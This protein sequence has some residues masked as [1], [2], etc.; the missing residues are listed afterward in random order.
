MLGS[1]FFPARVRVAT[2]VVLGLALAFAP[3]VAADGPIP[4]HVGLVGWLIVREL[5]IGA[6]IGFL[7]RL[8]VGAAM[9]A[10]SLVG[11]QMGLA[12][13]RA[14]DP[15]TQIQ[16]SQVGLVL[17][18]I[19]VMGL[20]AFDAHHLVIAGL[21]RS[22]VVAPVGGTSYGL[23]AAALMLEAG[24]DMFRVAVGIAAPVILAVFLTNLG[25]AILARTIPQMNVFVVGFLLTISVGFLVLGMS[26]PG[27][28]QA[29]ESFRDGLADRLLD[30]VRSL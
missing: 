9:M 29:C 22:L 15:Q 16:I 6:A 24:G 18:L 2:A 30:L 10:G 17:A 3:G 8:I 26:A 13:S 7:V 28:V 11:M 5:L 20:L 25:M 27:I 19:V 4:M 1:R 23:G 21:Y 12:L 14:V